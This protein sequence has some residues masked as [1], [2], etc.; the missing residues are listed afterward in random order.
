MLRVPAAVLECLGI[1]GNCKLNSLEALMQFGI[2]AVIALTVFGLCFLFRRL[3]FSQKTLLLALCT[4]FLLTVIIETI[5]T[6]E[7]A[8]NYFFV[9][10]F[11]VITVIAL[12]IEHTRENAPWFT[13]LILCCICA[14]AICNVLFTYKDC[15][16]TTDNLQEYDE[17]ISYMDSEDLQYGY[18]EFWDAA[19]ICIM[20]DGR[21]TMGHCYRM[22]EL[23]MYWWTTSLKWYVPNL[24]EQMRTA[25]VVHKEDKAAFEA[26]F[27]DPSIVTIGFENQTFTVYVSDHNLVSMN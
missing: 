5:T 2:L 25:Y 12:L 10:W 6:A 16:T 19:R 8:H 18:A 17:V 15:L 11:I 21:I 13:R 14:F 23:H 3:P 24:P 9:V 26:Q 20:T 1:A 4:S 7:T 22:E 27:E